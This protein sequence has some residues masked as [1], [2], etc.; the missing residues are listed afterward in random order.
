MLVSVGVGAGGGG[1]GIVTTG[2]GSDAVRF[3]PRAAVTTKDAVVPGS[4]RRKVQDVL[5]VR[6]VRPAGLVVTT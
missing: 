2:L 3:A 5:V 1:T 6:Q 4:R